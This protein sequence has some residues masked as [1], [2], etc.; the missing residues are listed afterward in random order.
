MFVVY[1]S[2]VLTEAMT[3][4]G[5]I[6]VD[7]W[8]TT[9]GTDADWIVKIIDEFPGVSGVAGGARTR[10]ENT[11]SGRQELVRAGVLRGRVPGEFR[12]THSDG[13]IETNPNCVRTERYLSYLP[14]R[15]QD[16]DP[17]PKQLVPVH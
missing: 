9:T 5:S 7:L 2:E 1:R 8:V 6:P 12:K 3:V 15:T 16:H 11:N 4:A 17:S 14:A 10:K 13:A